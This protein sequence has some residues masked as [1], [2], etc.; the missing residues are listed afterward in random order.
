M[1]V[2]LVGGLWP[3]ESP[4]PNPAVLTPMQQTFDRGGRTP[5]KVR[6]YFL[7]SYSRVGF[8]NGFGGS[9]CAES[10]TNIPT[11]VKPVPRGALD[12]AAS[13]GDGTQ[14]CRNNLLLSP[15]GTS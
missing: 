1:L 12:K 10:C 14:T 5:A 7:T 9:V 13:T 11:E 6:E 4:H 15:L 3:K 2:L 8:Q